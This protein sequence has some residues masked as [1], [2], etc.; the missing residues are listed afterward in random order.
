MGFAAFTT[1]ILWVMPLRLVGKWNRRRL[2]VTPALAHLRL[3][4][5]TALSLDVASM[6]PERIG[7]ATKVR[8]GSVTPMTVHSAPSTCVHLP[9]G[10]SDRSLWS[11]MSPLQGHY[12]FNSSGSRA[13]PVY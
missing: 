7:C 13:R 1:N 8:Q 9:P 11:K 3:P 12:H 2:A 10:S 6:S 5:G 4:C